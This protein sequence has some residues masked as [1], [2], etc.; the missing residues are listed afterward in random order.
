M[1]SRSIDNLVNKECPK[2]YALLN[3]LRKEFPDLIPPKLP[4]LSFTQAN[5]V[6]VYKN[7]QFDTREV[8]RKVKFNDSTF[9]P[10][11]IGLKKKPQAVTQTQYLRS[12]DNIKLTAFLIRYLKLNR[13]GLKDNEIRDSAQKITHSLYTKLGNIVICETPSDHIDLYNVHA[14]SCMSPKSKS[15]G[16]WLRKYLYTVHGLWPS[17][18]YAHNPQTQGVYLKVGT[19]GVTRTI[20]IRQ[21][22]RHKFKKYYRRVYAESPFYRELFEKILKKKGFVCNSYGNRPH[23][24]TV[25]EVPAIQIFEKLICPLPYHDCLSNDYWWCFDKKKNIFSFGPRDLLPNSAHRIADPYHY[26]GYM[27]HEGQ[28]AHNTLIRR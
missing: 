7:I 20:L 19:R 16:T 3:L 4:L 5:H 27:D 2:T 22:I 28:P 13:Y 26:R 18:W 24:T 17:M 14:L 21:D 23:L 15:Y 11:L 12:K 8:K 9:K 25:F 10:T 6:T 1:F